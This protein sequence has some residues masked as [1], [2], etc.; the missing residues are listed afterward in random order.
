MDK[1]VLIVF[2]SRTGNTA[3]LADE[4]RQSLELSGAQSDIARL[5]ERLERR[6][7]LIGFI[8]SGFEARLGHSTELKPL[9]HDPSHYDLVVIGTPVWAGSVSVPVRTFLEENRGR[10]KEV[11]FFLSH[12]GTAHRRTFRQMAELCMRE[13][14]GR[15]RVR[16]REL[17]RGTHRAELRAFA[18]RLAEVVARPPPAGIRPKARLSGF[19]PAT[20][21]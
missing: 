18:E 14:V 8:R 5:Q 17:S 21:H 12:G 9:E 1:K 20:S 4:I 15:L 7:G 6:R 10:L 11:A 19:A 16:D 13:P 2:Y 3:A